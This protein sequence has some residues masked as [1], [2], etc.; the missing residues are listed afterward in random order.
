MF[1][2]V[3]MKP[4]LGELYHI[5]NRGNQKQSIFLN[6]ENYYHFL[7]KMNEHLVPHVDLLSW[8]LMPNHFHFL[9]HANEQTIKILEGRVLPIT[10]LSDGMRKLQS[11]Y[12]QAFNSWY[13]KS[14]N[15][16]H[17]KYK[18]KIIGPDVLRQGRN[19]FHYVHSN[20]VTA[21]LVTRM[22]DWKF[23][24]YSEYLYP[25]KKGMCNKDMAMEL[26]ELDRM[27]ILF[28]TI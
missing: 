26:L 18:H 28:P 15:L 22:Q 6:E 16:F 20:P 21:G 17:Q 8:T 27:S 14:G 19:T 10:Q 4:L 13:E 11:S 3:F 5:Y 1:Y 25:E 9:I 23:S 2:F 7:D 12:T 24:S